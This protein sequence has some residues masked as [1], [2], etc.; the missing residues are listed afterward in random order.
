MKFNL[1]IIS[2]LLI[3]CNTKTDIPNYK[4]TNNDFELNGNVKYLKIQRFEFDNE[5]DKNIG[6]IDFQ[7]K[8][9]S[10]DK[11]GFIKSETLYS[12]TT[13]EVTNKELYFIDSLG[14]KTEIRSLYPDGEI[15]ERFIMDYDSHGNCLGWIITG[16]KNKFKSSTSLELDNRGNIISN[17][18]KDEDGIVDSTLFEYDN[19]GNQTKQISFDKFSNLKS[20]I[21]SEY[22]GNK[23]TMFWY[24]S[25]KKLERIYILK[26]DNKKNKIQEF[27]Y[28][29][30]SSF[31][32][33]SIYG[34][35]LNGKML[36]EKGLKSETDTS[37]N[38]D[39]LRT[40]KYNSSDKK[41]E[42]LLYNNGSD[43]IIF[44]YYYN[45]NMNIIKEVHLIN[46]SITYKIDYDIEYDS[47]KNWI[48][49]IEKI[50]GHAKHIWTREIKYY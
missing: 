48:K 11:R 34:Y 30:D 20:M 7:G 15:T 42:E 36:F 39:M 24:N 44:K 23:E 14:N 46:D 4:T 19:N 16:Y 40:Y 12:E 49:K 10:F 1:L 47:Y 37:G 26:Y 9:Y 50:N 6:N 8:E 33:G 32:L 5:A 29:P 13:G 3:S 31:I 22:N 17:V 18:K 38:Y 45:R 41:T 25:Q 21:L 35:N 28:N 2:L 43:T 27:M